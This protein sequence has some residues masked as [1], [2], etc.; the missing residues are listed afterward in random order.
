MA[1]RVHDYHDGN[2]YWQDRFDTRRLADRS[3]GR[4]REHIDAPAREFIEGADMFF[5][6]TCDHR[7]LP[8]CSYKGGDPGF[9]RVLDASW[10]AFPNYDGNGKYQSMGNLLKNPCVGMLFI[11]FEQGR[12]L[13]LQGIAT[14]QETDELLPT[15][16]GAQ[17]IVRVQ[18]TEVYNN[19]PR[20]IHKY[21]RVERS[22]YVP[23]VDHEPPIPEWK[24]RVETRDLLPAHDPAR[25][26][27]GGM[28]TQ[29]S[30]TR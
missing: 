22:E 24:L 5:L 19:C 14:I 12:R 26:V 25:K 7:G 20:Y 2:R 21:Q 10:L 16:P 1:E 11:A 6:A 18:V 3:A 13:R 27:V 4:L 30:S 28:P 9:V 29:E 15:Y 23:R 8:T 17:F